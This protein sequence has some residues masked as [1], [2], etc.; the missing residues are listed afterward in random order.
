MSS[1]L[2]LLGYLFDNLPLGLVVLDAA[3]KVV[4]FN[5]AEEKLAGRSR[6]HVLG[7]DFFADIAPCMNVR[8]LAGAF[9][10]KVGHAPIDE[11]IEMSFPFAHHEKPRDVR[12][13]LCSFEV[14]DQPF[15]FL[16]IEDISLRRA[17]DRMREQLQSLLVHDLKNPLAAITM[18]LQLLQELDTVRDTADAMES[19]EQALT[20]SHRLSRMTLNLLDIARLETDSMPLRRT[21]VNLGSV[22]T[23][24]RN[25]NSAIARWRG[26]RIHI[27]D[28]APT[29]AHIDEDLVVRA[30][31]NLVENAARQAANVSL[32]ARSDANGIVFEVRDDGPG[33]PEALRDRLFDK[34]VQVSQPE[35]AGRG[36]NRGL[37]L[38]FVRLVARQHGGDVELTC[39][40]EGGSVFTLRLANE[41]P[42]P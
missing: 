13:R 19:I 34:F 12:V 36:H 32:S 4:V 31:D 22:M 20:A 9:R 25:D 33:V 7:V 42:S 40:G 27:A 11:S 41:R 28:G 6:E 18:S 3:G 10:A 38:T 14:N 29:D 24:V 15:G 39:P 37:G 2:G 8:E 26:A 5:R 17:V 1:S 21:V 30:L 16:M 23:R 35:D